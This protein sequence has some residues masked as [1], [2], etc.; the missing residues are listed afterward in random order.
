VNFW[1]LPGPRGFLDDIQ[2][3]LLEGRSVVINV[4]SNAP[5]G[6]QLELKELLART[7]AIVELPEDG[8]RSLSDVLIRLLDDETVAGAADLGPGFILS[9]HSGIT[10][11]LEPSRTGVISVWR[12]EIESFQQVGQSQSPGNRCLFAMMLLGS[13]AT[14]VPV[15]GNSGVAEHVW[16]DRVSRVDMLLYAAYAF[17]SEHTINNEISAHI[18]A[19][20]ALFDPAVVDQLRVLEFQQIIDPKVVFQCLPA[21]VEW[22]DAV[23]ACWEDGSLC[24]MDGIN[25]VHSGHPSRP[26]IEP[27]IWRAQLE[28]L[29]PLLEL[30]RLELIALFRDSLEVPIESSRSPYILTIEDLEFTDIHRQLLR[31]FQTGR[32]LVTLKELYI[33]DSWKRIRNSLA[34]R[35][36]A[37]PELLLNGLLEPLRASAVNGGLARRPV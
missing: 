10:F 27:L 13:N 16:D 19:S 36:V 24:R 14:R 26:D 7:F 37:A 20:V 23:S 33:I 29:F 6:L 3:D 35:E 9:Q 11:W 17:R 28:V 32:R 2:Q 12:R 25:A 31:L 15:G 18:A 5:A 1:Q 4:P 30:R 21:R 8:E 22:K 34:H